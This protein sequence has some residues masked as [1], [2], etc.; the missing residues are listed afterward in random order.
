MI[1]INWNNIDLKSL[2]LRMGWS[3]SDLARRLSCPVQAI[4]EWELGRSQPLPNVLNEIE[5]LLKHA[6]F[7]SSELQFQPQI[8]QNLEDKSLEQIEFSRVIG[9]FE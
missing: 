9:Q 8:E 3:H 2:R 5:L 6:D 1:M 7:L 4:H